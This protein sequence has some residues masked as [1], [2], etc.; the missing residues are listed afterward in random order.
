MFEMLH[1]L[2]IMHPYDISRPGV[3]MGQRIKHF[4]CSVC[5]LPGQG[6][7]PNA[8]YCDSCRRLTLR[9]RARLK[10]ACKPTEIVL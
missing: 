5:G 2:H 6:E 7:S 3:V 9:A 10:K 1:L 8:K 4:V